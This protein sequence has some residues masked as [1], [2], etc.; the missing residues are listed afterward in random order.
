MLGVVILKL[1]IAE[2]I[3]SVVI[4]LALAVILNIVGLIVD[5]LNP[6]LQWESPIAALKQNINAVIVILG[7]ML[8]LGLLGY[9]G[10]TKISTMTELGL[11]LGLVPIGIAIVLIVVYFSFAEKCIKRLEV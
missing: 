6:R 5:T 9:I 8:I 3:I 1:Q 7:E 10:F 4:S 11:F 2:I